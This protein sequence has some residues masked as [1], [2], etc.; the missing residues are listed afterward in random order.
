ME[1][2]NSIRRGQGVLCR[3]DR[4]LFRACEGVYL[5]SFRNNGDRHWNHMILMQQVMAGELVSI[6]EFVLTTTDTRQIVFRK[7]MEEPVEGQMVL[8]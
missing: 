3:G 2:R 4:C 7:M 6:E 8:C 5:G 1:F